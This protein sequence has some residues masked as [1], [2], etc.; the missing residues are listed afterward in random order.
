MRKFIFPFAG[1][2]GLLLAACLTAPGEP[3]AS[4]N[5]A[6]S[7]GSSERP[8]N[9]ACRPTCTTSAQCAAPNTCMT[10]SSGVSLCIDYSACAYLGSDSE[11]AG[12]PF[13]SYGGYGGYGGIYESFD[14]YWTPSYDPYSSPYSGYISSEPFGCGGNAVWLTAP[15]SPIDDPRCGEAH[16]VTRCA[17]VGRGCTLVSGTTMDVADR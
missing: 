15:P 1:A 17:K 8:F 2:V 5:S 6:L 12:V 3:S 16:P 7:C 14:P 10:V 4:S 9:G 13:G 11:C